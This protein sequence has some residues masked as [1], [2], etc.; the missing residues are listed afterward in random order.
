MRRFSTLTVCI[1][2]SLTIVAELAAPASGY[3]PPEYGHCVKG[4]GGSGAWANS[5]CTKAANGP[6]GFE[7]MPIEEGR[8]YTFDLEPKTVAKFET[9]YG[10]RI[11]CTGE[12]AKGHIDVVQSSGLEVKF[13]GCRSG[14]FSCQTFREPNTADP[15]PEG[16]MTFNARRTIGSTD[17]ARKKVG[18]SLDILGNKFSCAGGPFALEEFEFDLYEFVIAPVKAGKALL[19]ETVK[20]K[21]KHGR[22]EPA[23]FEGE[24]VDRGFEICTGTHCVRAGLSA[25]F[26]Q[27]NS[28]AIEIDAVV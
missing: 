27:T 2:A 20:Y 21:Q 26:L 1:S 14:A 6:H 4:T 13:S 5:V 23:R 16:V 15:S 7:W 19:S 28:E 8:T 9:I 17:R 22:Q 25:T 24:E 10:E 12:T 3:D 18:A 11:E